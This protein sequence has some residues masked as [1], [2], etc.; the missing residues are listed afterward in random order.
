MMV[1]GVLVI[2]AETY[3]VNR[4]LWVSNLSRSRNGLKLH[5]FIRSAEYNYYSENSVRPAVTAS[6]LPPFNGT[7]FIWTTWHGKKKQFDVPTISAER[8]L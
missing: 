3:H 6:I 2:L 5:L 4:N 1:W 7:K 8:V